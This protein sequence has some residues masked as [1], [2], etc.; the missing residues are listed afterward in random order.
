MVP[1]LVVVGAVKRVLTASTRPWLFTTR[2]CGG[3]W[4]LG[5][6]WDRWGGGATHVVTRSLLLSPDGQL[7]LIRTAVCGVITAAI[8]LLIRAG[9]AEVHIKL[10]LGLG[11]G[12]WWG[13]GWGGRCGCAG[14][15][16]GDRHH[17][18]GPHGG[19]RG[20][21]LSCTCGLRASCHFAQCILH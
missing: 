3:V 19:A 9:V 21:L 1:H 10:W 15:G 5:H 16:R 14:C 11:G 20:S 7:L 6:N 12:G 8:T 2:S 13:G 4:G 17:H 18:W